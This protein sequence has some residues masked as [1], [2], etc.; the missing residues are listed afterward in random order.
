MPELSKHTKNHHIKGEIEWN[1]VHKQR[2]ITGWP[3]LC[4]HRASQYQT[5][6]KNTIKILCWAEIWAVTHCTSNRLH[7]FSTDM[8]VNTLIKL[9]QEPSGERNQST[10]SLYYPNFS[11]FNNKIT[12]HTKKQ[13]SVMKSKYTKCDIF[14]S[15]SQNIIQP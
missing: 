10:D 15:T 9:Q 1:K 4:L 6:F 14:K 12:R 3:K 2:T 5:R 8:L 13:T 11:V 7:R